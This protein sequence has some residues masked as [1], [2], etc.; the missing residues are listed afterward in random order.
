MTAQPASGSG[1]D[2]RLQSA[3]GGPSVHGHVR[4][5]RGHVAHERVHLGGRDGP[6]HHGQRGAVRDRPRSPGLGGVHPHQQQGRR[7]HRSQAGLCAGPAGLRRWGARHGPRPGPAHHRHLLGHLRRPRRLAP[8]ARYAIAH[9]RQLRGRSP[10]A[11]VRARR[12]GCRDRRRDRAAAGRLHHDLPLVA[13]RLPAGARG[14]RGGAVRDQD[15]PGRQI[16]G[17]ARPRPRRRRP[18]GARH[19]RHRARHP[20]LGGR[21]PGPG[22]HHHSVPCHWSCSASGSFAASDRAS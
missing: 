16:H 12:C 3:A 15:G 4:A 10:E 13:S 20:R 7:P 6:E 11:R 1:V 9:P 22:A 21:R 2:G 18:V 19:G 17:T 8:A 14:H 5:R